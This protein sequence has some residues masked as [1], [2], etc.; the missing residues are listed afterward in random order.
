MANFTA[1]L[2]KSVL[3]AKRYQQ[4][5]FPAQPTVVTPVHSD[6]LFLQDSVLTNVPQELGSTSTNHYLLTHLC[7]EMNV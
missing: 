3:N 7:L 5:V 1:L 6:I 2:R 4:I